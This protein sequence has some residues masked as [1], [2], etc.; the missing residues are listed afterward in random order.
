MA[1][2]LPSYDDSETLPAYSRRRSLLSIRS[3]WPSR[4]SVVAE[5]FTYKYRRLHVSLD[6]PISAGR[7]PAYGFN[8]IVIGHVQF[9]KTCS[10][11][12]SLTASIEAVITTSISPKEMISFPMF[13][14]T[15]TILYKTTL[16]NPS[17]SP[18]GSINGP[19][20][21]SI[22]FPTYFPGKRS[23]LPP[24]YTV[25]HLAASY[26]I[27]YFLRIDLT[28]RGL[29]KHERLSIPLLY[30]PKRTSSKRSLETP[31]YSAQDDM[32]I[33]EGTPVRTVNLLSKYPDWSMPTTNLIMPAINLFVSGEA[34]PLML[35]FHSVELPALAILWCQKDIISIRLIKRSR[36][37]P[38][39]SSY[40]VSVKDVLISEAE[41]LDVDTSVEGVSKSWWT[42]RAGAYV[43]KEMS[44]R[45][46]GVADV[47]YLI[48]VSMR[49]HSTTDKK[50][51]VRHEELIN[52][53]TDTCI[54]EATG[55]SHPAFGLITAGEDRPICRI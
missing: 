10:H 35:T 22:P 24:T 36:V 6:C 29:R 27:T 33:A 39:L 9:P 25:Q 34:I 17:P 40:S 48:R 28:R 45:V 11:V 51:I 21:F 4:R 47:R 30:L 12:V 55:E 54:E 2:E 5:G 19:Y 13:N 1:E 16:Y 44:W 41:L 23:L 46:D 43:Q 26:K 42:V 37:C 8:D 53:V 50:E 38:R 15:G 20:L 49:T 31:K 32:S 14:T 18:S 52:I 7:V 3:F